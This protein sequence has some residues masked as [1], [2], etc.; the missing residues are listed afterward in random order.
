MWEDN[1]MTDSKLVLHVENV[2]KLNSPGPSAVNNALFSPGTSASNIRRSLREPRFYAVSKGCQTGV[3]KNWSSFRRAIEGYPLQPQYKIYH[4]EKQCIQYLKEQNVKVDDLGVSQCEKRSHRKSFEDKLSDMSEETNDNEETKETKVKL[5]YD[6]SGNVLPKQE[7]DIQSIPENMEEA[8]LNEEEENSTH[9][10]ESEEKITLNEKEGT[11]QKSEHTK[12]SEEEATLNKEEDTAQK[13]AHTEE[14]EK[15][16]TGKNTNH[17]NQENDEMPESDES[18]YFSDDSEG[19]TTKQNS[20][21]IDETTENS[22]ERF[23]CSQGSLEIEDDTQSPKHDESDVI[24]IKEQVMNSRPMVNI[25]SGQ[26]SIQIEDDID[27]Y[28]MP[29]ITSTQKPADNLDDLDISLQSSKCQVRQDT[30]V[31]KSRPSKVK[32]EKS[33]HRK[34]KKS[35]KVTQT[36]N[37]MICKEDI[38]DLKE[39]FIIFEKNITEVL[40]QHYEKC[41]NSELDSKNQTIRMLRLSVKEKEQSITSIEMKLAEKEERIKSL[42]VEL[43]EKQKHIDLLKTQQEVNLSESKTAMELAVGK[44]EGTIRDLKSCHD[45]EK[46]ELKHEIQRVVQDKERSMMN[47]EGKIAEQEHTN[48][49]LVEKLDEKQ[50]CIDKLK[51]TELLNCIKA[52]ESKYHDIISDLKL[53]HEQEVNSLKQDPNMREKKE[54]NE[55]KVSQERLLFSSKQNKE[56]SNF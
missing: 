37:D 13:S 14:K 54:K 23:V 21:T 28:F 45:R 7:D 47:L 15:E 51:D 24:S 2:E 48:R 42:S 18:E 43:D 17:G 9:T 22:G 55:P 41:H 20:I 19:E 49:S 27:T 40:T 53:R 52:I 30:S 35:P 39:V 8:N 1:S 12:E 33:P 4:T 11:V 36:S 32:S 16:D 46:E 31:S 56:L 10:E 5:R 6:I 25:V 26:D 44:Y 3:F 34:A 50:Q 29:S 38:K